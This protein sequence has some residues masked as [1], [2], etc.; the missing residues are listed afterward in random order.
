MADQ[1]RTEKATPK[2]RKRA[3][4]KGQVARSPDLSGSL[5]LVAGLAAVSV[6]APAIASV[7][8]AS[9]IGC[10]ASRAAHA[11]ARQ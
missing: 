7:T 9:M 10:S 3:R 8:A 4:D 5:V 11:S 1:D 2:H 6:T